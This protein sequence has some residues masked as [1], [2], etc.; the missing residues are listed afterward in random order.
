MES[1]PQGQGAAADLVW[2]SKIPHGQRSAIEHYLKANTSKNPQQL[3]D[4]LEGVMRDEL[5]RD[6]VAFFLHIA[7]QQ[8][9]GKFLPSHAHRVQVEREGQELERELRER[10]NA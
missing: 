6:P 2:P 9:A 7:Q 4:E 10:T 8:A 5:V 3:L 1:Y